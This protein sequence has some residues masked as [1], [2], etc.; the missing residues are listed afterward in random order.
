ML[1]NDNNNAIVR[2]R[3]GLRAYV[4]VCVR[5]CLRAGCTCVRACEGTR[6]RLRMSLCLRER[7]RACECACICVRDCL[8]V[9]AR[10]CVSLLMRALA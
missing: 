10:V 8:H 4:R 2:V 9:G 1:H 7:V 5:T 6:V 3:R